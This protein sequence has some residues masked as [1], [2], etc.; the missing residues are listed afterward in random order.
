M[1][2][3]EPLAWALGVV[4]VVGALVA[5]EVCDEYL[6][7]KNKELDIKSTELKIKYGSLIVE[8]LNSN[9]IPEK[10]YKIGCKKYFIE[11]DGENLESKIKK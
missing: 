4:G 11:I 9:G 3:Y 10:F 7:I 2:K 6:D 5:G 8:D 1:S